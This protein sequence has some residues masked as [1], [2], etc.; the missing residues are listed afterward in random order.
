LIGIAPIPNRRCGCTGIRR[1]IIA[2]V[3]ATIVR[4]RHERS[5]E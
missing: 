5:P 2:I 3:V 4:S 1:V